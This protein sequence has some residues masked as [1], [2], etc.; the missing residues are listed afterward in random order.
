MPAGVGTAAAAG[1]SPTAVANASPLDT[2]TNTAISLDG[3]GSSDPDGSI[4]AYDWDVDDDNSYEKSGATASKSYSS[5]GVKP[6][7]LRVTDDNGNTDT[8]TVYITVGDSAAPTASLVAQKTAF[9][10]TSVTLNAGGSSDDL[11]DGIQYYKW[12]FDGDNTI[13]QTTSSATTTHSYGSTGTYTPSVTVQDYA[14][15]TA[16]TA[17]QLTVVEVI[18]SSVSH[19][20]NGSAPTQSLAVSESADRG[21]LTFEVHPDG[22]P[23]KKNL[24]GI[25]TEDTEL[26]VNY[27]I[28]NYGA[29]A[30]MGAMNVD[31]WQTSTSQ[32]SGDPGTA[33]N[34]SIKVHP[35]EIQH[36]SGFTGQRPSDWPGS[37]KQAD[38][39]YTPGLS[40]GVFDMP[41]GTKFAANMSG[42]TLT[43]DAQIFSPPKYDQ[44][45][46]MLNF[47]VAAPHWNKNPDD[48]GNKVTNTGFYEATIPSGMV[49]W[50][51]INDPAGLTG[52]F[53]SNS[54]TQQLTSKRVTLQSDGDLHV[55][56]TGIHYS[57]GPLSFEADDTDPTAEA[58]SDLSV[59]AGET[60]TLDGG[61]SSDDNQIS[62]YEWDYT[63]DG[64][65][66]GTGST[67]ETSFGTAGEYTVELRVTDGNS[68]TD[69]DTMTVSVSPDVNV[70]GDYSTSTATPSATLTPTPSPTSTPSPSATATPRSTTP[71]T[72][73]GQ[74]AQ[75]T[76]GPTQTVG[77]QTAEPSPGA[78]SSQ[79]APSTPGA[80][81]PGFG[82]MI[83]L[84]AMLAALG[85][86][87][88]P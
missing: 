45:K 12:D 72:S 88:R 65:Y 39:A 53:Y 61:S 49:D 24:S 32:A 60:V 38:K 76:D 34:L 86:A 16:F 74:T 79:T 70:V 20:G 1:N 14:G 81:G 54:G 77:V 31:H 43:T 46:G 8:D 40:G 18:R 19:T 63:S 22:N 87:R 66:E 82:V 75:A 5:T 6:I 85:V 37:N 41:D 2:A 73:A 57:G 83:T 28:D 44:G 78:A 58:G 4:S 52:A 42:A 3:S 13:D 35:A 48:Q 21:M 7:T 15:N 64:T 50:M 10:G 55:N 26:W 71:A 47:S 51:G 17:N 33:N 62:S 30:M 27:T 59:T 36:W 68:N 67:D 69:T 80:N 25:V 9:K 56:V 23:S 11:T 29:D 84:L